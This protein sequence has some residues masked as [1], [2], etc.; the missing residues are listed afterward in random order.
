GEF[1][2]GVWAAI[3]VSLAAIVERSFR[4]VASPEEIEPWIPTLGLSALAA[5]SSPWLPP[6]PAM[7]MATPF[8][9]VAAVGF[10][11]N[12]RSCS[13][14]ARSI[15]AAL[16]I[17]AVG[18]GFDAACRR[19]ARPDRTARFRQDMV[20]QGRRFGL[21]LPEPKMSVG[22]GRDERGLLYRQFVDSQGEEVNY[23]L[24]VPEGYRGDHPYPLVVF[25]HGYG[26]RGTATDR[27]YVEVGLPFTL[28]Y[29]RLDF[30]VLC[31]Q[32]RSGGWDP[33]GADARKAL[34][35]LDFVQSEY[36]VDPDRISLTGLSNGGTG[37]W[38]MAA[39]RPDLWA[40]IVPVAG[41]CDPGRAAEVAHIPCWCFHDRYDGVFPVE[42]PRRMTAAM[43]DSG[44]S[45]RFTEYADV[46]HNAGERAY[47]LPDLYEWLSHQ[48]R[49]RTL[50]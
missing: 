2:V 29:R 18:D 15:A 20:R 32:G 6:A 41:S 22:A 8:A 28:K 26:D 13:F 10:R 4:R 19:F 17:I 25:L 11:R 48:R 33:D 14:W 9:I 16:S 1:P 46:N 47:V 21:R 38:D 30:L 40:A 42:G 31:P 45:P 12:A 44:G 36:R 7:L 5:S 39:R 43:K 34:E 23:A 24:Y 37:A 50:P 49:P 27:R 35:L 3:L